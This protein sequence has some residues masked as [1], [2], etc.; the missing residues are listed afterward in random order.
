MANYKSSGTP[1]GGMEKGRDQAGS[2][3][4]AA[5]SISKWPIGAPA[6]ISSVCRCSR[7]QIQ[8]AVAFLINFLFRKHEN[9]PLGKVH[10]ARVPSTSRHFLFPSLRASCLWKEKKEEKKHAEQSRMGRFPDDAGETNARRSKCAP[11]SS[12]ETDYFYDVTSR[13]RGCPRDEIPPSRRRVTN[14]HRERE[15][16]NP[17]P[18]YWQ[19]PAASWPEYISLPFISRRS[20]L[21]TYCDDRWLGE[22]MDED[23]RNE[24]EQREMTVV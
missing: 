23:I 16:S 5:Y 11:G 6:V 17:A 12:D 22:L 1:A 18:C 8:R 19:R 9:S 24:R 14:L 2:L 10:S 13:A 3:K 4:L 7:N 21:I 15:R 20:Y